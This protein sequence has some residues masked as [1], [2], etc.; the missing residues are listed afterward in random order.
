MEATA[1]EKHAARWQNARRLAELRRLSPAWWIARML[2]AGQ[3]PACR[4]CSFRYRSRTTGACGWCGCEDPA[5]RNELA[6]L[7]LHP[8][9]REKRRRRARLAP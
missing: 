4:V 2:A 7:A 8:A 5:P 3:K 1:D 6:A 9:Q